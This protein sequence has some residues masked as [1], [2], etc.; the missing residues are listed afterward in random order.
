VNVE[1]I[2][3]V[4]VSVVMELS[5]KENEPKTEAT[6]VCGIHRHDVYFMNCFVKY[7]NALVPQIRPDLNAVNAA[8]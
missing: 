4:R 5:G 8:S 2:R 3:G 6:A 7:F 1:V